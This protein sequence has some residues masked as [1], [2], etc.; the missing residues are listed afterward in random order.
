MYSYFL[1]YKYEITKFQTFYN[2]EPK[3]ILTKE[4]MNEIVPKQYYLSQN[5]SDYNNEGDIQ[6][7][8][9]NI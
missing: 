1:L 8:K 9:L 7:L 6:E 4:K 5:K 3:G 2:L